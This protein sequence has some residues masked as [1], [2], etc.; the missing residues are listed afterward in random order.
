MIGVL[1]NM[2]FLK[3]S[4]RRGAKDFGDQGLKRPAFKGGPPGK[5]VL[6]FI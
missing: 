2:V 5:D 6:N 3:L 4:W 1:E